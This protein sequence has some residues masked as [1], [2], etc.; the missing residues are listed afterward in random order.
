MPNPSFDGAF[1]VNNDG[2][3]NY[4]SLQVQFQRRLTHGLQALAS[5]SW[6]HSIDTG[7]ASSA[8]S[9]S[10][11]FAPGGANA[12]RGPSDFDIRH[13]FSAGLT[14]QIVAPKVN[15]LLDTVI[16]GWS[17]QSVV[18]ARSAP[19]VD[20]FYSGLSVFSQ[21][22][23]TVRPDLATGVPLYLFGSQY[24]G[25]K[26]FN[27]TPGAIAGGCPDGS[28]SIGPFCPP[29][30]ANGIPVRQ[31]GLSRNALRGFGATQWDF[32][33]H[34][35][36]PIHERL[37]LQFRAEFFNLLNH[38]NFGSPPG[39]LSVPSSFGVSTQMLG[40]SLSGSLGSGVSPL[41]QIGGPRSI[42][43]ALK[44]VF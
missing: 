33:V 6:A 8:G 2:N 19:P 28:Q 37:K 44:L 11:V 22:L 7:S 14:Y 3:S 10:N 21:G 15:A 18:Q 17:I 20:V 27:N 40:Q 1:I 25:G 12:N 43:L 42:Q 29:P 31:G 26:A 30:T 38:P 35:E 41:Y 32:A 13:A 34:R 23:A 4:Q 9:F 5:Y 16:Q 36:F 24:P 39:D